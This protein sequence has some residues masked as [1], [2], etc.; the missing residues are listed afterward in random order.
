MRDPW[1][2][3]SPLAEYGYGSK[4][5]VSWLN[6][7]NCSHQVLK[8]SKNKPTKHICPKLSKRT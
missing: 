5:P 4:L 8:D 3:G 2:R 7:L 1:S 6:W